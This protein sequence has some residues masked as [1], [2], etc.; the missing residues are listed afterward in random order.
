[1]NLNGNRRA[2]TLWLAAPIVIFFFNFLGLF[3]FGDRCDQSLDIGCETWVFVG[4]TAL[5]LAVLFGV[6]VSEG[7]A[8]RAGKAVGA[9]HVF[10]TLVAL[11]LV[12]FGG[13]LL[14]QF[15]AAAAGL[16]T[17][18]FVESLVSVRGALCALVLVLVVWRWRA[19][20]GEM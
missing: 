8:D 19:K 4:A 10:A 18:S 16:S 12:L 3:L 5:A 15:S 2:L 9:G 1:M 7:R 13:W 14:D 11:G 17:P 20:R 6:W